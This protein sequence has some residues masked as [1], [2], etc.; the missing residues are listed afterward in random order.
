MWVFDENLGGRDELTEG[1]FALVPEEIF[2][3]DEV[4]TRQ[5][6]EEWASLDSDP[7]V[8]AE[9]AEEDEAAA[10][11]HEESLGEWAEQDIETLMARVV[12]GLDRFAGTV[13]TVGEVTVIF[14][15]EEVVDPSLGY[16]DGVL[17]FAGMPT[18]WDET[19]A[20]AKAQTPA[21]AAE[22][23]S[24]ADGVELDELP[25]QSSIRP[26]WRWATLEVHCRPNSGGL[27]ERS[28]RNRWRTRH[29]R[30]GRLASERERTEVPA[31]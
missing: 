11:E 16:A 14:L 5:E 7:A 21:T 9:Q 6:L 1:R 13:E 29:I 20:I 12:S 17:I 27:P 28:P 2:G 18:P 30:G 25:F 10:R 23:E 31:L 26:R 22:T 19:L 24:D 4:V 8:L 3:S 15:H